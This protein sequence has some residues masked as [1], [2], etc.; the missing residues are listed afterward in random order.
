VG[1]LAEAA[2]AERTEADFPLGIIDL[3]EPDDLFAQGLTDG[4][5]LQP[6]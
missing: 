6:L 2:E 3:D 5:L 1:A 4:A